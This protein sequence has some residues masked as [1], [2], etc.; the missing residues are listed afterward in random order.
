MATAKIRFRAGAELKLVPAHT[1]RRI[2]LR[3]HREAVSVAVDAPAVVEGPIRTGQ[4]LGEV[5]VR[6]GGKVVST[7]PLLAQ[8]S[9]PP[10]SVAQKTKAAAGRPWIL[11]G[12]AIAAIAATVLVTARRRAQMSRRRRP[13]QTSAA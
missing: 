1:V 10:A 5:K 9:V 2:V 7:V 3:G 6:Q 13:R 4:R 11:I 12:V 8:G